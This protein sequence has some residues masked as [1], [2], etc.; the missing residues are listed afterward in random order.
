MAV[1]DGTALTPLL[2][3][4]VR[5][6]WASVIPFGFLIFVPLLRVL[7]KHLRPKSYLTLEEAEALIPADDDVGE[8]AAAAP[9]WRTV[10]LSTVSLLQCS[11]WIAAA[12]YTVSVS[13]A[14]IWNGVSHFLMA[15]TWLYAGLRPLVKPL[16]SFPYD[17]LVLFS[18]HLTCSTVVFVGYLYDSYVLVSSLEPFIVAA[19]ALNIVAVTGVLAVVMSMPLA[20]PS[21]RIRKEDIVSLIYAHLVIC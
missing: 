20:V 10:F 3:S 15:T 21:K 11:A 7:A 17:L 16:I 12:T 5:G 18:L 13:P 8:D 4:C 1:C 6:Y 9:L 2:G 19:N 14:D